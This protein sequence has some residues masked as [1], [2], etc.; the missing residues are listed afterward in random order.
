MTKSVEYMLR[1]IAMTAATTRVPKEG[2]AS[3]ECDPPVMMSRMVLVVDGATLRLV[4]LMT[5]NLIS[6][7]YVVRARLLDGSLT[8]QHGARSQQ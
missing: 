5:S 4:Q 3:C 8:N 7:K 1:Y 6:N 2:S